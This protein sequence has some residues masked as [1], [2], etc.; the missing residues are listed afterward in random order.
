MLNPLYLASL[1]LTLSKFFVHSY[2]DVLLQ[3]IPIQQKGSLKLASSAYFCG[4]QFHD[5][6]ISGSITIGTRMLQVLL[7]KRG[8]S[9][10]EVA[11]LIQASRK[12]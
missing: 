9:L 11:L 3:E 2:S 12:Y 7:V 1:K 4:I 8:L 10:L 6:P 5:A